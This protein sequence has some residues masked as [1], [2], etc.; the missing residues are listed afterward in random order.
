MSAPEQKVQT[1]NNIPDPRNKALTVWMMNDLGFDFPLIDMQHLWL[2]YLVMQME[3]TLNNDEDLGKFHEY[4][5]EA[6]RY[7]EYHFQDEERILRSIKFP[8]MDTHIAEHRR[9]AGHLEKINLSTSSLSKEQCFKLYRFL[10]GWLFGHISKEDRYYSIYVDQRGLRHEME[11]ETAI[12]E[13]QQNSGPA[14]FYRELMERYPEKGPDRKIIFATA[15]IVRDNKLFSGVPLMDLQHFWLVRL[16]I[17][18]ENVNNK[19]EAMRRKMLMKVIE[20]AQ[21]YV[22]EHFDAEE[23]L[24][25]ELDM[26]DYQ[27]HRQRHANFREIVALKKRE[28]ED[29]NIRAAW[30]LVRNLKEW[31]FSHIVIEDSKYARKSRKDPETASRISRQIMKDLKLTPN[32]KQLEFYRAVLRRLKNQ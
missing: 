18:M 10:R 6:V 23:Y 16:I 12:P 9:F 4:F 21:V 13:N 29:G 32:K 7:S 26:P 25:K 1:Q 5:A 20:E 2:V 27:V 8:Q 3:A 31:L 14:K 17:E 22:K 24:L 30:G 28:A 11:H 15:N 19:D